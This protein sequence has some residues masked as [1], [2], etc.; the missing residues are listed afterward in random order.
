MEKDNLLELLS[1]RFKQ[2]MHRH[3]GINWE[4]IENKLIDNTD[5]FNTVLQMEITGGEPDVVI[6]FNNKLALFYCDC[7]K[8]SPKDRRSFCYDEKALNERKENKPKN[9]AIQ[10]AEQIGISLLNELE[11]RELQKLE[12]FDLKTSS[13]LY[14]PNE[15]RNLGGAI[16]GDCRYNTTFIYHNGAQSYY[17]NRGIRGLVKI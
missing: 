1:L 9:S 6:L 17:A 5:L 14:T 13:W 12:P 3:L 11:Y 8:E 15:I 2:N 7:S 16:F 10:F 4:E